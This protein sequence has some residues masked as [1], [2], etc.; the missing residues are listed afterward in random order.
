MTIEILR[1]WQRIMLFGLIITLPL[2]T[3]PKAFQIPGLGPSLSDYFFILGLCLIIYEFIK[4]KFTIDKK[5]R[6]FFVIYV[7]WQII[8]LIHGL[9]TYQFNELLTLD[10]ISKLEII[11]DKL[12]FFGIAVNEQ[13]AIKCWLFIRFS[14]DIVFLNNEVFLIVFYI[15][16]LYENNFN[17]AFNDIRKAILCLIIIMGIY[18]F[19]ELLWLKLSLNFAV[20]I[21][22]N[23]NP[24]L[25]DPASNHGWWPPLLWGNQLRS[26][27]QEP[28]FLGIISILSLP[29]LWS[30]IFEDK[31]RKWIYFLVFYFSLMIF[32]TNARTA[33]VI[34]SGEMFLLILSCFIIRKKIYIRK[35]M[36]IILI[37]FL[38]FGANLIDYKAV[39]NIT[40][41]D[42]AYLTSIEGYME[43][44][45]AS[46]ADKDSRSNTAR[47][48]TLVANINT[49]IE[50]P[51][52]G[53]GTGLKDAYI[54]KN[55]PDF[56]YAD[57]E[58]MNR[59][60]KHMIENGVLKS[61]YPAL[62]KYADVAVQN[63]IVGLMIYLS[64][65]IYL[66]YNI[67]RYR[68][69]LLEDYRT[70]CLIISMIGLLMA[71]ISNAALISSNGI[72]WG[73]LYCVIE[74]KKSKYNYNE[75]E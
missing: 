41:Q 26:I 42:E 40:N 34:T 70:V 20:Q 39:F 47:L 64:V 52:L 59:W 38:A 21:L 49:V 6:N 13:L 54:D 66:L 51:I 25:Y 4:C 16:H 11:L 28:S 1:K 37:A 63:G 35:V 10:Q 36:T 72:V 3:I 56:A 12:N 7:L 55:L 30:Y 8:C 46:L 74:N 44:N 17:K 60:H 22:I 32:A 27:C 58:V 45:I 23:I 75:K 14:K 71:Q 24:F 61:G 19:I 2:T 57:Y 18:S 68:K 29:I 65:V 62:N 67:F 48:S 53:V 69:I 15:Y 31:K 9:Y 50:Y 73:L 43:N 5:I 33:I